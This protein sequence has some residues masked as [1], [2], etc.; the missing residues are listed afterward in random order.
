M[1]K[2]KFSRKRYLKALNRLLKEESDVPKGVKFVFFP[3]G[4]KARDA[5]GVT[6]NALA[7]PMTVAL[8]D[9]LQAAFS[10]H[11]AKKDG[12]TVVGNG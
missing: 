4:A 2:G 5:V 1:A 10:A 6:A 7:D 11:V 9:G 8:M 3:L 12:G